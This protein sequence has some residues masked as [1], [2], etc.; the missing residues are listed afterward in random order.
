MSETQRPLQPSE[1]GH[2]VLR[3]RELLDRFD[4]LQSDLLLIEGAVRRRVNFHLEDPLPSRDLGE[5]PQ[6]LRD[7]EELYVKVEAA[8]SEMLNLRLPVKL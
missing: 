5:L 4:L 6:M 3:Y 1:I 7:Y 8:K 2:A